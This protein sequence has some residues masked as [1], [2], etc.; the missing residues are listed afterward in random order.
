MYFRRQRW[1]S[2]NYCLTPEHMRMP[3]ERVIFN[4]KDRDDIA[5]EGWHITQTHGGCRSK[6]I[7]VLNN[8]YNSDKSNLLGLAQDL[9]LAGYSIF[10]FDFRSHANTSVPQSVGYLEQQDALA[11]LDTIS[12][13]QP[14]A[15]I[16]VIGA[17]MGGAVALM[18]AYKHPQVSNKC[19]NDIETVLEIYFHLVNF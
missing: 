3:F 7:V 16:A 10:L 18:T 2:D 6:R 11:A 1:Y 15:K 13:M 5:L 17:S 19:V 12:L 4:P 14:D 9:W 8:P